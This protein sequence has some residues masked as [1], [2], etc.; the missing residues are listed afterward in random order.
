MLRSDSGLVRQKPKGRV[1]GAGLG[2]TVGDFNGCWWGAEAGLKAARGGDC[3]S[4]S[5]HTVTVLPFLPPDAGLKEV[6]GAGGGVRLR[7]EEEIGGLEA[8][9]GAAPRLPWVEAAFRPADARGWVC[10]WVR[11]GSCPATSFRAGGGG[12]RR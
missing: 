7:A 3:T 2:R 12:L 6:P 8:V 10:A 1:G 5:S 11:G 4:P 9:D